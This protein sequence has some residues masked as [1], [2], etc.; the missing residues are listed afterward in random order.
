MVYK[1]IKDKYK[2]MPTPIKATLWYTF[3]NFLNKGIA[4]LST[5]IFTRI[6]T[7]E[8]YGTFSIFQ[9]WLNI[10]IIFTSL[11]IFMNGYTKGLLLYKKDTKGFTSSQL[12]LTTCLTTLFAV[13]YLT[14]V[15]FWTNIFD[16]QPALMGAMLVELMIM[17]ALEFWSAK[18]RFDYKYKK[19]VLLSITMNILSVAVSIISV[20]NSECKIEAR[21]FSDVIVKAILI[22]PLFIIIMSQGKKLFNKEY[23]TYSLKFNIR[24]IPHYLS[25]FILNQ[26]DRIMI[27]KMVG[28]AEA[29]FYSVSYTIS[30]II[31]LVVSAINNSL[32]PFI[33]KSISS[34][35]TK[36]IK[37][38]I[39]FLV[40]IIAGLCVI[41]MAFAPEII[42]VFAGKKYMD[43]IYVIPPVTASVFF[44]FI[45]SLYSNIE[46]YYQKTILVTIATSI[47]AVINVIMNFI[48]IKQFGYY[49]AGYTTLICYIVLSLCHFINYKKVIKAEGKFRE[50]FY[51]N[52][53]IFKVG[54]MMI[55]ITVIMS[56]IYSNIIIRYSAII[57]ILLIAVFNKKIITSNVKELKEELRKE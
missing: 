2:N 5:P 37:R 3:C 15:A 10:L 13:I 6:L 21:I 43:A 51:D 52:G 18:Q 41:T 39:S 35:N 47:S 36:R 49:A 53:F 56:L 42:R 34:N 54:V 17:P 45:Y 30:N 29:A 22:I 16:L 57:L 24:L 55:I 4:L 20:I 14:N 27:G 32:I 50:E 11:N 7:E 44:I 40:V 25:N 26:S 33:Y 19:V 28:K 8:Q 9:S 38:P 31:F 1:S 23:G 46:Y 12:F 48:A